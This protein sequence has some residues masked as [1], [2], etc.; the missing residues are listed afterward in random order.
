MPSPAEPEH[1]FISRAG[2]DAAYATKVADILRESGYKVTIQD[3][4]RP[5]QNFVHK[6]AERLDQADHTSRPLI[7]SRDSAKPGPRGLRRSHPKHRT[8]ACPAVSG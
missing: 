5:G 4:F 7:A 3:D 2:E 8:A 1:F 6:I